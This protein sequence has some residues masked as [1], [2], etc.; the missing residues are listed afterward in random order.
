MPVIP[1]VPAILT[2]AAWVLN[3]FKVNIGFWI[4]Y[5]L[6]FLVFAGSVGLIIV[7][8]YKMRELEKP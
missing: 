3:L 2:V 7:A 8:Q 1:T 5:S 4:C 6:C